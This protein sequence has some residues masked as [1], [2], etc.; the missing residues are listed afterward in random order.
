MKKFVCAAVSALSLVSAAAFADVSAMHPYVRATLPHVPNT[1]AFL[2]LKNDGD[3]VMKLVAVKSD[4]PAK[5]EL[6]GHELIDG[7][8]KMRKV[9][10]IE[11]PAKGM[12]TLEPGGHHI[13]VMGLDG[14]L[15]PGQEVDFTLI[16]E[17]GDE[18]EFTAPV[19]SV[20]AKT[21]HKH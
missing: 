19:E 2:M 10:F 18:V 11:V 13:M 5:V 9:E 8:M 4:L 17:S 15:E 1:A 7:L 6:H 20:K 3:K 12:A 21:K 16:F 14:Q